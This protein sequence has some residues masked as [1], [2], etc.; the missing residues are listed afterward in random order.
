MSD[1]ERK[2]HFLP[3]CFDHFEGTQEELDAFQKYLVEMFTNMS[4]EEL[5]QISEPLENM[6]EELLQAAENRKLQ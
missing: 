2:V 3:G 5:M 1:I 4:E 6:P